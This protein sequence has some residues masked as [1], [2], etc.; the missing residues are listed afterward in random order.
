MVLMVISD[1][2]SNWDTCELQRH[3]GHFQL[4]T[5]FSLFDINMNILFIEDVIKFINLLL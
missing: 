4:E 5:L 2:Q 1:V 3:F